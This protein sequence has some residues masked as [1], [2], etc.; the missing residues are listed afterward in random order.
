MPF[1]NG[2][3]LL[4]IFLALRAQPHYLTCRGATQHRLKAEELLKRR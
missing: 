1:A 2:M 4:A 3:N